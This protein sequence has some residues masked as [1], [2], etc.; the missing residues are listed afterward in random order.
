MA[1]NISEYARKVLDESRSAVQKAEK[2]LSGF[3]KRFVENGKIA[4]VDGERII[5]KLS[6][7]IRKRREEFE[8]LIDDGSRWTLEKINVP[9]HA[10]VEKLS[11]R[12]DALSKR[13]GRL[14][15]ELAA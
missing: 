8:R 15:K 6:T 11:N 2:D 1:E 7:R 14:K 9:T 4:P 3:V 5:S 12:I 13:I 10:E